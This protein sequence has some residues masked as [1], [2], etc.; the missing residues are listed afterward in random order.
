MDATAKALYENDKHDDIDSLP[1]TMVNTMTN[2]TPEPSLHQRP[3]SQQDL[4]AATDEKG[5]REGS[6]MSD[7]DPMACVEAKSH[8][9]GW[10]GPNDPENPINLSSGQKWWITIILA[11]VTFC[12]SFASS[13]FSTATQI[14][15]AKFHVSLEVMILGVSLYVLGFAF[16]MS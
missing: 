9:V 1:S 16:G 11:L 15:A 5:I 8:I 6:E 12:V 4:E 2:P 14:T 13:V 7:V 10:E 3:I